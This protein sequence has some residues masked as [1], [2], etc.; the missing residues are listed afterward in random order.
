MDAKVMT[1]RQ[2]YLKRLSVLKEQRQSWLTHWRD[3]SEQI[4]PR[5]G[6][7]LSQASSRSQDGAKKSDK[8]I[9]NAPTKAA[10]T[11]DA[12]LMAGITSPARPW[13]RLG[14]PDQQAEDSSSVRDWLHRVEEGMRQVF[15]RSNIYNCLH[16]FYG[17]LGIFGT[18]VLHVEE[19]VED[20]IRGYVFPAGQYCLA[21]DERMRIDTIY[22]ETAMT[23]AQLVKRFGLEKCSRTTRDMHKAGDLDTWVDVVHV[24]SPREEYEP[25]KL[26]PIGKPFKSCWLEL[27][28]PDVPGSDGLLGES[29]YDEFPAMCA[30]WE[31]NGEDVYGSSPGMTALGDCRSLQLYEK[32]KAELVDKLSKPPM[33]GPSSMQNQRVSLLPG[34]ITY[35][36]GL[37]PSQMFRAAIEINPAG[38][39]AVEESCREH[40]QR[41]RQAFFADLWLALM[42][43]GGSMT[44]REVAERHE[45]KMLQLGPVM[46]RLQ[47]ELLDPLID[48]VFDIGMRNGW[49]PPPPEEL[50]GMPLRVEYISIMAAAQKLLGTSAVERLV[51]FVGSMASVNPQVLDKIDSDKV[52][53]E[54]ALMLGVKPDL[55]RT[56]A[57]VG[58]IRKAKEQAQ[59]QAAAQEQ[60]ALAVQGA[61]TLSETPMDGD[62]ALNRILGGG[63]PGARA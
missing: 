35:S 19:D 39:Q 46:E 41:I 57:Q 52:I 43:S 37:N 61:K 33:T 63:V 38:I 9:N 34:D 29:G 27:N 44:A 28:A 25:G 7:F 53:D 40:E 32:R 17:D 59:A 16:Q 26:G 18:A 15:A 4:K 2:R 31:V 62:T 23:V 55:V 42:E 24:I 36:D 10:I 58:A 47:D 45:E 20:G 56:E 30:R 21:N 60:A 51:G 50:S 5:R 8:I 13:F 11:L 48:R 3:L 49:F 54:Y 1:Q 14:L 12:G 6:R 22:R